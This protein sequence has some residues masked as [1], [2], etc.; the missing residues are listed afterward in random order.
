MMM[1]M[2]MMM[3]KENHNIIK[4]R[5][6]SVMT[7]DIGY[8]FLIRFCM[9]VLSSVLELTELMTTNNEQQLQNNIPVSYTHLTLPTILL[10]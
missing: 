9:Y 5:H 7:S 3:K 10:V 2:M 6:L 4:N 1:M 8:H